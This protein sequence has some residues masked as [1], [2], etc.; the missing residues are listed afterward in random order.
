MINPSTTKTEHRALNALEAIIDEHDTMDYQFFGNDKEM[1]WDGSIWIFK[2]N[3]GEESKHNFDGRLSVQIKGS[4]R[5]V[6][7]LTETR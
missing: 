4:S 5:K 3:N 2:E 7:G 1:S 6:V